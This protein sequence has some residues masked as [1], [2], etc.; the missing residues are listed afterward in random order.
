MG[1]YTQARGWL[2]VN[3]IGIGNKFKIENLLEEAKETFQ[4]EVDRDWVCHDTVLHTGNNG[5]IY[6]FFGTELKNYDRECEKW[7]EHLIRYFPNAEGRIDFQYEEER[8]GD[9]KSKYWLIYQGKI[10][11]EGYD[12]T[13][14]YGYGNQFG[15]E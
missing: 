3:S 7:I 8:I 10:K 2:N 6:L 14:C 5:S 11:K 9:D 12:H 4:G 13:W 1:M 15:D